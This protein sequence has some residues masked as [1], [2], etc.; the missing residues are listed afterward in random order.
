[1]GS[2]ICCILAVDL[3][4]GRHMNAL[5]TRLRE[6]TE[7]GAP[8]THPQLIDELRQTHPHS[9]EVVESPAPISR[10]TCVVHSLD[11]VE[12]EEYETI[13]LASPKH[14]FASPG[15]LQRLIDC[16]VL[17]HI[18]QPQPGSLVVYRAEGAATHVGKMLSPD[19]VESKWGIGH[20]YRHALLE[21][22][23]HD[24]LQFFNAI[25]ADTVLDELVE[26][27]KENGV[28]FEGDA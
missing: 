27:A 8:D 12:D 18:G 4:V 28:E 3:K 6:I 20:L 15:F 2:G 22:P 21:V 9:I 7:N 24:E 13:V 17:N 5:R 23:S 19:R 16:E 11:L 14:V 1:M 26:F 10:Y 25:D